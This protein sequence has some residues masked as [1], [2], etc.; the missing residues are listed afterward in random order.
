[1]TERRSCE[2]SQSAGH[3]T[4]PRTGETPKTWNAGF[5]GERPGVQHGHEGRRLCNAI[6]SPRI[7]HHRDRPHEITPRRTP[8]IC[9]HL[10]TGCSRGKAPGPP[11]I[12]PSPGP[13]GTLPTGSPRSSARSATDCTGEF[14]LGHGGPALD[15]LSFGVLV[16]LTL[17]AP[18]GAGVRSPPAAATRGDVV[19]RRAAGLL[20]L[21]GTRPLLV[22]SARCDLLGDILGPAPVLQ[23]FLDVVVLAFSLVTPGPLWHGATPLR[24]CADGC[25]PSTFGSVPDVGPRV[26]SRGRGG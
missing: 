4:S 7:S 2:R 15:A 12:P 16:E 22:H 9:R 24:S 10:C 13:A 1:M 20:R 19:G 5:S 11:G 17:G 8:I 23:T 6:S 18:S 14:G 3:T 21:A 26:V 25:V